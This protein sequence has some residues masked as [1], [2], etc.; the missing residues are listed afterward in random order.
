MIRV[1][2]SAWQMPL[3]VSTSGPTLGPLSLLTN[4]Y[5]VHFSGVKRPGREADHSA[6]FSVTNKNEWN[7]AVTPL[8]I[9]TAR[10]L[11]FSTR[12][13]NFVIKFTSRNSR[14]NE[15]IC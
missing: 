12:E 13:F 8:Y 7:Y 5:G 1:R 3:F 15:A 14:V 10:Y 9:C 6:I 11:Q 2:F 4:G